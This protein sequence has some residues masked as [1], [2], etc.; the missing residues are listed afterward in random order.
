M[1]MGT[2][3][4]CGKEASSEAR[5][6]PHCG[7]AKPVRRSKKGLVIFSLLLLTLISV[8][9]TV[10]LVTPPPETKSASSALE[11]VSAQVAEVTIE[12]KAEETTNRGWRYELF[13]DNMSGKKGQL[14]FIEANERLHFD[15][16]YNGGSKAILFLRKHP[17]SGS[18]VMLSVSK[19]HFLCNSYDGCSVLIRF[20]DATS[21]KYKASSPSDHS[22]TTL[23]LE[24]AP[25]II[26]AL[27]KARTV[28]VEAEFYQSGSK[29]M[30]FEAAN[31]DWPK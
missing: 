1:A 27:R 13:D 11:P 5:A 8:L 29:V 4:E 22:V 21:V 26:K 20:D 7:A 9:T 25:Q 18:D 16:P 12:E 2:C 31:L 19:G 23:F 15:F 28:R 3:R 30:T 14:A 10:G 17:R 24:P 6:C